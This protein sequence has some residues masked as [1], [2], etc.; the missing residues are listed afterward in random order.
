MKK[1]LVVFACALMALALVG[2]KKKA[3]PV[4]YNFGMGVVTSLESSKT[5]TAQVD[6][7]VAVVV[8]DKDGKIVACRIDVAQN[9]A[10]V[11]DGVAN[12]PTSYKTK[13]EKQDEY[14][15][16]GKVDNDGNG[17]MLEWYDQV[18]AFEKYVV[19]KTGEEVKNLPTALVNG[20]YISTDKELL[21]AG[22]SMQIT[23]F[24]E[25]VYKACTDEQGF[26]FETEKEFTVGVAADSFDDRSLNATAEA[27]GVVKMYTD[28]A[29]SVIV[30]GKIVASIND[31]IQP[32]VKF[33]T[34]GEITT[35]EYKGTKRELKENYNMAKL[36][37]TMDPNGDKKVYEWYLQSQAFSKHVVG[38]T[39]AAVAAMETQTNSIGYQMT[40]DEALLA[41]GCTIQITAIKAVVAESCANAR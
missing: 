12:V 2:C 35:K 3:Q 37:A 22:C 14:G 18:Y 30:E 1:T 31:A 16:A 21:N 15:M 10:T 40:T 38:M 20:H 6:A 26:K 7:T 41:A 33:N 34:A 29:G 39:G 13:M 27:D 5:G 25:A 17:V 9:K 19:G 8:T 4:E 28:F 23:D 11:T 32:N 24:M 36:G